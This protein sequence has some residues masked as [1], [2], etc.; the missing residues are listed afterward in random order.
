M[1]QVYQ[2]WVCGHYPCHWDGCISS[3]SV[4]CCQF[5]LHCAW[6]GAVGRGCNDREMV[7]AHALLSVKP[8]RDDEFLAAFEQAKE[9]ISGAP[10][11][12]RLTLSRC[13]ERA[14]TYVLLVE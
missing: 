5:E 2:R 14:S 8:G 7:L 4:R 9:I 1:R 12:L 11:F 6:A 10:G 3:N 13:V